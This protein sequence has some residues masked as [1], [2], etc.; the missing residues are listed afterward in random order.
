[1]YSPGTGEV[2]AGYFCSSLDS[3]SSFVDRCQFNEK[4]LLKKKEVSNPL[5]KGGLKVDL[6]PP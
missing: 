3:Q 1:M 5:E 4:S 2:G 6:W